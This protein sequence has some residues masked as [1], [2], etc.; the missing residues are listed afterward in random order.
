MKRIHAGLQNAGAS[1]KSGR[2]RYLHPHFLVDFP[3]SP[4]T[5]RSSVVE[6]E[7]GPRVHVPELLCL[8]RGG[9]S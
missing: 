4:R 1:R 3:A 8:R 5:R 9:R 7:R 6:R 2:R